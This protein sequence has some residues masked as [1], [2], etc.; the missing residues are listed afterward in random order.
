MPTQMA[1]E[2][3]PLPDTIDEIT[4]RVGKVLGLGDVQFLALNLGEPIY[5]ERMVDPTK[6]KLGMNDPEFMDFTLEDML[7]RVPLSEYVPPKPH[8][9][10]GAQVFEMFTLISSGGYVPSHVL[11]QNKAMLARWLGFEGI[12]PPDYKLVN[13]AVTETPM[14]EPDALVVF[15]SHW[16]GADASDVQIGLK[17]TIGGARVQEQ[18]EPPRETR[19]PPPADVEG[20][21]GPPGDPAGDEPPT[22]FGPGSS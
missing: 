1:S 16:A 2:E 12:L 20:A 17:L 10:P 3:Y 13:A 14:M 9:D 5:V 8:M 18:H 6:K 22:W 7:N 4:A 19:N 15:G 21:G 11:C